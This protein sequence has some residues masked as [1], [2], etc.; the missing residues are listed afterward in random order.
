MKNKL[1][2]EVDRLFR[3]AP[4]RF[5]KLRRNPITGSNW[6]A[7]EDPI[8]PQKRAARRA[9]AAR[10]WF[11]KSAPPDAPQ[12]PL[13]HDECQRLKFAACQKCGF[14]RCEK[15]GVGYLVA[16]FAQ[17]IEARNYDVEGHPAFDEY[18][19]G[20]LAF[21]YAPDFI[22]QDAELLKR[23]PPRP[24][25]GLR[26]GLVW[27]PDRM[28]AN[29][30]RVS[31]SRQKCFLV[32]AVPTPLKSE[33]DLVDRDAANVADWYAPWAKKFLRLPAD[34]ITHATKYAPCKRLPRGWSVTKPKESAIRLQ[35][36]LR[37]R[38]ADHGWLIER[39]HLLDLKKQILVHNLLE[40]P[41]LCPT[42][43]TAARL[44]QACYPEPEPCYQLTWHRLD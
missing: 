26:P 14:G 23:F 41:V 1:D 8:G 39:T 4:D 15:C 34:F 42:Y 28:R 17:S 21:P 5:E 20:V 43:A 35:H 44:A 29:N 36:A 12:L 37:V 24:L 11:A 33:K 40:A 18:A 9:L 2:L 10:E 16:C 31:V 38:A 3:E 22:K 13:S 19:R 6:L 30:R 7:G 27:Q 32:G 25:P